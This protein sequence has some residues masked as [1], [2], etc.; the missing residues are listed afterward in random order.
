MKIIKTKPRW[1][2]T[3][4]WRR[5][6]INWLLTLYFVR[7]I[8][9]SDS[10][11]DC[12]GILVTSSDGLGDALLRLP[13]VKEW[14]RKYPN[15][16]ILTKP[17]CAPIYEAC[18]FQV[19]SYSNAMM[20]KFMPR[21]RLIRRLNALPIQRIYACEFSRND[22]LIQYL[23]GYKLGFAHFK[24]ASKDLELDEVIPFEAYT[25]K[26]IQ[27]LA[28]ATDCHI[29]T[30]DNRECLPKRSDVTSDKNLIVFAI[31]AQNKDRMMR[32]SNI[33]QLLQALLEHDS[34]CHILLVGAGNREQKYADKI[35]SNL[36]N[37][38]ISRV[39]SEINQ[40]SL[41]EMVQLVYGSKLLIGFDSG[42]YNL[43]YTLHHPT[44]CIAAENERV[45][46]RHARWV[47]IVKN[48]DARVYGVEDGYGSAI[49]NSVDLTE[50]IRAYSELSSS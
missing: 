45:L 26:R 50:F 34:E 39:K 41:L 49:T 14:Q 29:D 25:G 48:M 23:H 38:F 20:M 40:Y 31:G 43:S 6:V 10:R 7:F 46:H 36:D 44:L 1:L 42:L 28:Q 17:A 18:G 37:A 47:R 19:I 35:L 16:W 21:F 12:D 24:D 3:S 4:F 30:T 15:I 22:N 27:R 9:H 13:V 32:V 2:K 33:T 11:A 5:A 8:K